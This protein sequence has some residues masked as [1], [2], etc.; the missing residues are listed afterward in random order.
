MDPVVTKK[1]IATNVGTDRSGMDAASMRLRALDLPELR[2]RVS[3]I[4]FALSDP[5]VSVRLRAARNL[6]ELC[7]RTYE[8]KGIGAVSGLLETILHRSRLFFTHR[9]PRLP[10]DGSFNPERARL[11]VRLGVLM[12]IQSVMRRT[13]SPLR[14][15]LAQEV[16]DR[17]FFDTLQ[18]ARG[19]R[20]Y[21]HECMQSGFRVPECAPRGGDS[22]SSLLDVVRFTVAVSALEY[23]A[24]RRI[25]FPDLEVAQRLL[26]PTSTMRY[27]LLDAIGN[28]GAAIIEGER[29]PLLASAMGEELSQVVG[30]VIR[31][32][33][34]GSSVS[35]ALA[36]TAD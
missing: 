14:V 2:H 9:D 28:I 34:V 16:N 7:E 3:A 24:A 20:E 33:T 1:A 11:N 6:A 18:A 23:E 21:L 8:R 10:Q 36:E 19:D 15:P 32:S 4:E 12:T 22:L 27:S 29:D 25:H 13:D 17:G 35:K 26:N 30:R 5:D 31:L